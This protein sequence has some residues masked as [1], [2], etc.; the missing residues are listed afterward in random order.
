M[1]LA[2]VLSGEC[3]GKTVQIDSEEDVEGNCVCCLPTGG[4]KI[5]EKSTNLRRWKSVIVV[6]V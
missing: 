5:V 1:K 4:G 6:N 2:T 3:A